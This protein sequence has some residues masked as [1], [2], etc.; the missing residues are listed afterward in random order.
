[1]RRVQAA[2][3]PNIPIEL[4]TAFNEEKTRRNLTQT[5][6]MIKILKERYSESKVLDKPTTNGVSRAAE[7]PL[8]VLTEQVGKLI[9]MVH[10]LDQRQIKTWNAYVRLKESLDL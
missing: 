5:Q 4:W 1:M 8:D 7:D 3:V 9:Q 2:N 10:A 6:L